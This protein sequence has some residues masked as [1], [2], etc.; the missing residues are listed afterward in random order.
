MDEIERRQKLE[1]FGNTYFAIR[2]S[3]V[4]YPK[5]MWHFKPS[6][7]QW[8]IH[9]IITHITDSEAHAYIRF[10]KAIAESGSKIT[11]YNQENWANFLNYSNQNSDHILELFKWLRAIS[12]DLL[13]SL[14]ESDW[15][16]TIIH[17]ERGS[18]TLEQLLESNI[19]HIE[20]HSSQMRNVFEAWQKSQ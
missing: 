11:F 13:R 2:E 14:S 20:R 1:T 17:P 16:N 18:L 6:S 10:R 3:L 5:E 8:S 15:Q 4:Q 12:Y 19:T 9:E 7:D